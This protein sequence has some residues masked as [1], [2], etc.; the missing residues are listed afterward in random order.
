MEL[1]RNGIMGG[2]NRAVTV[3][4]NASDFGRTDLLTQGSGGIVMRF[5]SDTSGSVERLRVLPCLPELEHGSD[6]ADLN[7]GVAAD[8]D[9]IA[10]VFGLN[11]VQLAEVCGN[12]TRPTVYAWCAGAVPRQEKLARIHK[13]RRAALNWERSGFGVPGTAMTDAVVHEQSLFDL[14]C[15]DP[16]NLEAIQ[17]AGGRLAM[18]REMTSKRSFV[19]PFP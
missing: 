5:F 7:T 9:V 2:L 12:V 19:D 10:R 1:T 3:V 18:E 15:A 13:L 17:F 6:S 8:L 14:L 4:L 11:K 16:L